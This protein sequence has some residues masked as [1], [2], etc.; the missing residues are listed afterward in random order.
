MINLPDYK[1]IHCIGIGGIGLSAIAEILLDRGYNVSGSDM[2]LSGESVREAVNFYKL[3]P[4]NL[5]VVYD[6]IDIAT[7][8]IRIRKFGSAGTHNG[9]RSI[10]YQLQTDRFPRIRVGTGSDM[11]GNLVDYVIGGFTKEEV[12]LLEEAVTNAVKAIEC[13]LSDGVDM[14]MNRYNIKKRTDERDD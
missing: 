5:I 4:E 11:K 6:D 13:I 9:M 14:A 1:N 3:P 8:T 7:G 2:N 12:P 10:V